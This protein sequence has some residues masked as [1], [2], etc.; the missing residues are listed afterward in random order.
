MR[1][2][3]LPIG[4]GITVGTPSKAQVGPALTRGAHSERRRA[5]LSIGGERAFQAV[6]SGGPRNLAPVPEPA[7]AP[8]RPRDR[9]RDA[10]PR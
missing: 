6:P 5:I 9:G 7:A 4:E 8:I 10:L 3:S 1:S 2:E